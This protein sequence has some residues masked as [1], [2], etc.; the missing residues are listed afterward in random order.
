VTNSL[1]VAN[2]F[3]K[4]ALEEDAPLSP[5]K[6][7]KLLYFAY[8]DY[9]QETGTPLF[10]DRICAWKYGPVVESVYNEFKRYGASN[11]RRFARNSEGVVQIVKE[12]G[13]VAGNIIQKV[14][15]QYKQNDGIVLS[16]MTHRKGTAWYKAWCADEPYLNDEDIA[17]ERVE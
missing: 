5:M 17:H 13:T 15:E 3:I 1:Y 8:R 4:K 11:I 16:R 2:S 10:S 7:Q 6:L 14:W 9:L 12:G